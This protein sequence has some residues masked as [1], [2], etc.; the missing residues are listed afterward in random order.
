MRAQRRLEI[1]KARL[2][3]RA[4]QAAGIRDRALDGG[5]VARIGAQIAGTQ[6]MR[7]KQRCGARKIEDQIAG[8]SG[9]VARR[10]EREF[11]A[12]GGG[13]QRVIVD[14]KLELPEMPTR[15]ADRALEHGKFIRAARGDVAGPGQKHG[16]IQ[17]IGETLRRLDGN[18]VAAIDQCNAAA[19]ER[20][21]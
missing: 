18:L 1:D 13:G 15:I 17:T 10:P 7:G 19:L 3:E 9:A 21:Q 4:D 2:V 11:C 20:D 16:D 12:R 6:F 5:A 8:G 14:R